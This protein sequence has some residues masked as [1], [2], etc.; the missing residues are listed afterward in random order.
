MRVNGRG[1]CRLAALPLMMM[2]MA[3]VVMV[4]AV[5]RHCV[6]TGM[7]ADLH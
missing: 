5:Q 4:L 7:L 6:N 2:M 3:V 1:P